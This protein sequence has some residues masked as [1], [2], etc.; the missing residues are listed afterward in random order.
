MWGTW[1][2]KKARYSLT[3]TRSCLAIS[4]VGRCCTDKKVY[5]FST[6]DED[7]KSVQLYLMNKSKEVSKI[8]ISGLVNDYKILTT[9]TFDITGKDK[10]EK[11]G[12]EGNNVSP[13][14]SY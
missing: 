12:I 3:L 5:G 10:K 4:L 9:E 8:E 11:T 2:K 1:V 14:L 13:V 6:L 7:T